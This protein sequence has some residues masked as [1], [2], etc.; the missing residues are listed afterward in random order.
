MVKI[1]L[2]RRR[3]GPRGFERLEKRRDTQSETAVG[4]YSTIRSKSAIIDRGSDGGTNGTYV[5]V[6]T[7][8]EP[9]PDEI[10]YVDLCV[11][12]IKRPDGTVEIVDAAELEAGVDEGLVGEDLAE[13]AESVAEAVERALLK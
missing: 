1:S 12:V 4:S 6:C 11:D 7:P 3:T 9:F 10:R 13:K 8:V 5:N 2:P